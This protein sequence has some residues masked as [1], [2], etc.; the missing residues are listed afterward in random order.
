M[1]QPTIPPVQAVQPNPSP[2]PVQPAPV[3]P[4]ER[5]GNSEENAVE[6]PDSED[7]LVQEMTVP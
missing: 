6:I 4:A 2:V 5:D 1:V 7:E 3:Q